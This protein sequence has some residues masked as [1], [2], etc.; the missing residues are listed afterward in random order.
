MQVKDLIE[1]LNDYRMNDYIYFDLL[2]WNGK[3]TRDSV[4]SNN[5]KDDYSLPR[6][7]GHNKICSDLA[8]NDREIIFSLNF[9]GNINK[10]IEDV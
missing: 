5:I 3:R 6:K 1:L 7:V 10:E 2:N 9:K 8:L 4:I